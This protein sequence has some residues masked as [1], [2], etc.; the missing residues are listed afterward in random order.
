MAFDHSGSRLMTCETDKTI[1]FWK[2]DSDATPES[3]PI[4]WEPPR[5]RKRY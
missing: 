1:K 3:H 2:E 5:D 4:N